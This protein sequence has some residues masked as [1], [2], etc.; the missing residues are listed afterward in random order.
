MYDPGGRHRQRTDRADRISVEVL[1][2]IE[3]LV[4]FI[5]GWVRV[6]AEGGYPERLLNDLVRDGVALWRVHRREEWVRFSC[7]A[8]DYRHIRPFA[9]RA[10]VRMRMRHNLYCV[11]SLRFDLRQFHKKQN[12]K[13]H[14][15]FNFNIK[16]N[17]N[18][19]DRYNK[20]KAYGNA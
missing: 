14:R 13:S 8:A 7:P 18:K 3:G 19:S 2:V 9:R 10:G 16:Q 1:R 6:E 20:A 11:A 15:L 4:R 12:N 5:P 17:H